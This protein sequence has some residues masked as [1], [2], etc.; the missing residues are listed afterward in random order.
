M[1]SHNPGFSTVWLV[2][3]DMEVDLGS[4]V[5]GLLPASQ[6]QVCPVVVVQGTS[7]PCNSVGKS[8]EDGRWG[9]AGCCSCSDWVYDC[10][11]PFWLV[12]IKGSTDKNGSSASS[13]SRV[14]SSRAWLSARSSLICWIRWQVA[15]QFS[16]VVAEGITITS[17][18]LFLGMVMLPAKLSHSRIGVSPNVG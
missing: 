4:M 6:T 3:L 1:F 13:T 17:S 12:L 7:V 2:V 5:L 16:Q 9:S 10:E 11:P 18:R 15:L 8:A 14:Y